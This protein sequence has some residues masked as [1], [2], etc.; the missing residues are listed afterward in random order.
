MSRS[1]T[2]TVLWSTFT[3]AAFA[4]AACW[5]T[6]ELVGTTVNTAVANSE[7]AKG[8]IVARIMLVSPSK[9]EGSGYLTS[10]MPGVSAG[11]RPGAD[12]KNFRPLS[13]IRTPLL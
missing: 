8:N 7:T 3:E 13:P 10:G 1:P 11:R 4:G 2:F 12:Q 5:A 6:P 9:G